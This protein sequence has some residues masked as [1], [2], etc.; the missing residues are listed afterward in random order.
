MTLQVGDVLHEL[1]GADFRS[2]VQIADYWSVHNL[3]LLKHYIFTSQA[4]VGKK[5]SVDLVRTFCEAF[6]PGAPGNRFV[7]IATYGHGKSH[8]A[9]MLANYFGRENGSVESTMVLESIRHAISDQDSGEYGFIED[10]KKSS[11]V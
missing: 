3:D 4:P 10:F 2:D 11:L 5:S 6:T 9:L 7:V 1:T 8:F